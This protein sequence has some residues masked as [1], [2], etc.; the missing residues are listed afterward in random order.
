MQRPAIKDIRSAQDLKRWYWLKAELIAY[1]K[2][3]G[4]SYTGGKFEILDRIGRTLHIENVPENKAL[5]IKQVS[6]FNWARAALTPDTLITDSYTNGANTRKFFKKYC[7]DNF[8]F[9]IAFMEW[10]KVNTNKT[11]QDAVAEWKRLNTLS[12]EKTYTSVIPKHNQYNQYI[13]DFFADNAEKSLQQARH[14][15]KLKTCLP[16]GKHVYE[17]SDLDLKIL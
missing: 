2:F 3:A 16:A 5:K 15:W 14:C 8:H 11:L 4:V 1:C 7:G 9:T 13:R 6:K 10:M 12:K 17:R